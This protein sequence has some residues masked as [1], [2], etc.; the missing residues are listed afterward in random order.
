MHIVAEYS[1][2]PR[3]PH[4][5]NS[6]AR[7]PRAEPPTCPK[8]R[9]QPE[10]QTAPRPQAT[11]NFTYDH[12]DNDG[13]LRLEQIR[14]KDVCA[15][16]VGRLRKEFECVADFAEFGVG[17]AP[18]LGGGPVNLLFDLGQLASGVQVRGVLCEDRGQFVGLL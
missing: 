14:L 13:K 8:A 7:A 11:Q 1:S 4:P 18:E 2:L 15:P 10:R 16:L 5:S 12:H 6:W 17:Q 9:N 3:H